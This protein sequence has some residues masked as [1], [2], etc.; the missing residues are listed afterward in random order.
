MQHTILDLRNVSDGPGDPS[1]H[2]RGGVRLDV[3]L[4][5]F[6]IEGL[7]RLERSSSHIAVPSLLTATIACKRFL[8]CLVLS[9]LIYVID[10]YCHDTVNAELGQSNRASRSWS[11][12][13][14]P[15]NFFIRLH[16]VLVRP[17]DKDTGSVPL[18]VADAL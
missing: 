9:K 2:V 5:T 14:G 18:S 8:R 10:T 11:L 7:G 15:S 3:R 1:W 17:S 12:S 4:G 6:E 16:S 13:H